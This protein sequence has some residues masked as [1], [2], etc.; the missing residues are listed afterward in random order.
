[1]PCVYRTDTKNSLKADEVIEELFN[2]SQVIETSEDVIERARFRM[3]V[4]NPP[5][6]DR[7]LGDAINWEGLLETVPIGEDLYLIADDRDYFSSLDENR[8]KEFLLR[9]WTKKKKSQVLFY[10]RLSP[11]FKEH[12]PDIKLA[13]ELEKELLVRKFVTSGAFVTT[14]DAV[15]KLAKFEDF[16]ES[17]ANEMAEAAL[18]NTQINWIIR[19][20]DVFAF[21][22][23]LAKDYRNRIQEE[24]LL[25]LLEKL[26]KRELGGD[27]HD[28][29]L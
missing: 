27:D 8:P 23:K 4:G 29:P 10:R 12:Y 11:F 2:K 22:S 13:S 14:H 24:T 18:T 7:S 17:Q 5:G 16:S 21:L 26:S 6:K 19:D 25:A 20:P 28:L 1:S 15:G 3:S 9:E